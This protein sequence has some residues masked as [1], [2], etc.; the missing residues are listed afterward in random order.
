MLTSHSTDF[1]VMGEGPTFDAPGSPTDLRP[2]LRGNEDAE[3]TISLQ[4]EDRV[5][6]EPLCPDMFIV[7]AHVEA[8]AASKV[9]IVYRDESGADIKSF[10]VKMSQK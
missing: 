6:V 8:Y 9:D 10:T 4:T 7:F 5:I 2:A 3:A 1:S